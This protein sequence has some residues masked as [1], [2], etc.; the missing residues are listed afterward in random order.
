MWYPAA[1]R[2][3][4]STAALLVA[5]W[6]P[7]ARAEPAPQAA[8]GA[9]GATGAP[10]ATGGAA[11]TGGSAPA[12]GATT[13]THAGARGHK[14]GTKGPEVLIAAPQIPLDE[15]AR[16]IAGL[17]VAEG[18]PLSKLEATAAWKAHAAELDARWAELEQ[19][20]LAPMG[21]WGK[22][23]LASRIQPKLS[24]V[25][26]FGGPDAITV[27]VLYPDAPTYVLAGLEPLGQIPRLETLSEDELGRS[28]VNLRTSLKSTIDWSFFVTDAMDRALAKTQLKGVMPVLMLFLARNHDRILEA[29]LVHLDRAGKVVEVGAAGSRP[30][31]GGVPGLHVRFEREG[32]HSVH[33]LYYFR[34]DLTDALLPGKPGLFPFLRSLGPSN[35]FLK[36]ASF[37]LHDKHFA[38][39]RDYLLEESA[40]ILQ[41]DS[42]IPFHLLA[43]PKPKQRAFDLVLFGQYTPSR[44]AFRDHFQADMKKAWDEGHPEPLPFDTGYRHVEGSDL[45]LALPKLPKPSP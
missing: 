14:R 1:M 16:F 26:L 40:S 44:K 25:Y 3:S 31:P 29:Q 11:Q 33:D 18:S 9:T 22:S 10:D 23:A 24:L 38:R 21:A 12:A 41:D 8:T 20:R 27:D 30:P 7:A 6:A 43:R 4:A 32:D 35:A 34:Q 5:M 36:A 17:P 2:R 28:L 39:T 42:G 13:S 45:L 15:Q 19:H 37:I